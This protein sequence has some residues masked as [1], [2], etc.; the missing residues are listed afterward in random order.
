MRSVLTLVVIVVV[1]LL[2]FNYL[3]TGKLAILPGGGLSGEERA[4]RR[5]RGEF[6][7]ARREFAQAG[8]AVA[9]S[10]VDTT[11]SAEAALSEVSRIEE[12]ARELKSSL[13]TVAARE[14]VERLIKDITQYKRSLR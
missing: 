6:Q 14:Q 1:G 10:G 9:M 11:A 12:E 8:R 7:D 2:A 5:L 3:T 4:V 13:K